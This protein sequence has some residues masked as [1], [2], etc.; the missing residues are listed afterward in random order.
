MTSSQSNRTRPRILNRLSNGLS[1]IW[2]HARSIY[3]ST[4]FFI[5]PHLRRL[6]LA[7]SS[8]PAGPVLLMCDHQLPAPDRHAGH[9]A[10]F[11]YLSLFKQRGWRVL[12]FATDPDD[13]WNSARRLS[14]AGILTITSPAALRAWLSRH[15]QCVTATWIARPYV[16]EAVLPLVKSATS[17][18]IVYFTHD[19]TFLRLERQALI[20]CN[21]SMA[22]DARNMKHTEVSILQ[23][24]SGVLSPSS[25][26][27]DIVRT[28][29]PDTPATAIPLHFF[30]EEDLRPRTADHFRSCNDLLFVGGFPHSPNVDAA[31]FLA[32]QVMPI[33]WQRRPDCRLVL[34]GHS[35][36][37]SVTRLA[38]ERVIVTGFVPDV[39]P[40]YERARA[41]IIGLR[42][43]AGVKGKVLEGMRYGVP[44]IGTSTA[45]EGIPAT[46]S[47]DFLLGDTPQ[48]LA[49]HAVS[50]LGDA[51]ACAQLSA[52]ATEL[53]RGNYTAE[54]AWH[55]V[56]S[57][58][59][60]CTHPFSLRGS[61]QSKSTD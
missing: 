5:G 18:P 34:V 6:Q 13:H 21:E 56:S 59:T 33:I 14:D 1:R 11:M 53:L 31:L 8:Q 23:K 22:R 58:L 32:E 51:A 41:A 40:F 61:E 49:S 16:A 12:Y 43:G 44:V 57:L 37:E 27:I 26:E 35:P 39:R 2:R 60:Q 24:V 15:G 20:E 25:H 19:L 10:V 52:A 30:T 50:L 55:A 47:Q 45:I 46:P 17:G 42:Y 48:D 29:V 28:L 54:A 38:G 7:L 36:P 4:P 3:G 9:L